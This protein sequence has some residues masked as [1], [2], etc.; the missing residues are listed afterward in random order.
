MTVNAASLS[1]KYREILTTKQASGTL[2]L[3]EF[4]QLRELEKEAGIVDAGLEFVG[5][6]G[7]RLGKGIKSLGTPAGG[8]PRRSKGLLG[9]LG[10]KIETLGARATKAGENAGLT[11][12]EIMASGMRNPVAKPPTAPV[13]KPPTAPA[14][15]A[16]TAPAAPTAATPAAS[17]PTAPAASA[18]D[19]KAGTKS[20]QSASTVRSTQP[21]GKS[22]SEGAGNSS[23]KPTSNRLPEQV[24]KNPST[25]P[26][27]ETPAGGT[28]AK[29][30]EVVPSKADELLNSLMKAAPIGVAGG[31]AGYGGLR[32]WGEG[33]AEVVKSQQ[34]GFNPATRF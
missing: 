5:R 18:N 26:A 6:L 10:T 11:P 30:G 20:V 13:A 4:I 17:A 7:S 33:Q 1:E 28:P 24:Q 8:L 2:S 25:A 3:R 27:P 19:P 21:S 29:D 34:Q 9:G 31:L 15:S 14:A 16:P 23:A 12:S 32:G 22:F